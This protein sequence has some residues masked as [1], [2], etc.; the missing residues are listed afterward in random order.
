MSA[1]DPLQT[2]APP[3]MMTFMM[4]IWR[5]IRRLW[6][7]EPFSRLPDEA[8]SE[9]LLAQRLRNRLMEEVFGHAAWHESLKHLDV[10]EHFETF[11]D[12]FP[13]EG[14][15]Y[16]N[17]AL[18]KDE[19]AALVNVH[20][21]VKQA[22]EWLPSIKHHYA[23]WEEYIATGWPQRIEPVAERALTLMLKRGRFSEE[24]EEETPSGDDGWP[25][26]DQFTLQ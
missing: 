23:S 4:K 15:P 13:Y 3:H 14:E 2:L 8:V 22:Y 20:A 25:W 19:R 16:P 7:A 6:G 12:R 1:F 17:E 18:T 10:Y 26:R 11:F 21:L 24:E 9:R 5:A